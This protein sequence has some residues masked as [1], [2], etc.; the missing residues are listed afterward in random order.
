MKHVLQEGT[1]LLEA[2]ATSPLDAE[3]AQHNG[4]PLVSI[5]RRGLKH[6]HPFGLYCPIMERNFRRFQF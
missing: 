1:P 4:R 3:I 5:V 2:D 6:K